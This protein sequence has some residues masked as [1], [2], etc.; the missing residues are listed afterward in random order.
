MIRLIFALVALLLSCPLAAV[1]FSAAPAD[2]YL[3]IAD[4]ATGFRFEKSTGS[5]KQAS[6]KPDSKYLITKTS[7]DKESV[8]G[9]DGWQVKQLGQ[10]ANTTLCKDG[11][12]EDGYLVC[13]NYL[14]VFRMN[15]NNGRYLYVYLVGYWDAGKKHPEG[16][17]NPYMEIGKCSSL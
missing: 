9:P 12:D 14:D 5:W 15:K 3:C 17:D 6:N 4:T 10:S 2:S 8:T 1:T 7:K 13:Y 11:F 16:N